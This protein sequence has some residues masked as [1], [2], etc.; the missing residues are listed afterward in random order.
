MK[1]HFYYSAYGLALIPLLLACTFTKQETGAG[2]LT[3]VSWNVHNLFDGVDNGYEYDEFKNSTG[4]NTEKYQGRLH[5]ISAALQGESG[6]KADIL[7]LIEVEN[8]TVV[9][10]LAHESNLDYE[11]SFFAGTADASVGLG[12]LSALPI[13]ETRTHSFH[14][15]DGSIPRPVAEVH[16]DTGSGPLVLLICHWKSKTGGEK[17]TESLRQACSTLIVRRLAEIEEEKE[18]TPVIIMGDLNE[19]YDEFSRIEAA[20]SCALLPGTD[21]AAAFVQK[22]NAG[23]RISTRPGFQNFL[24][25]TG[26]R[27]P[28]LKPGLSPFSVTWGIVYSPWFELEEKSAETQNSITGSYYYKDT[29]ETIDHFLLNAALFGENALSYGYFRVLSGPPF[30][31]A[32]GIPNSYNPRTGNGLSDHLPIVLVLNK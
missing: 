2:Y 9:Q 32:A 17:K 18:G 31:N 15:G 25:L 14:S 12:V 20:Y 7:A 11:W 13:T 6:I 23:A 26:E 8:E 29:W 10:D 21:E 16:V 19:N 4:W 1:K 5:S 24:V 27:P 3:I 28:K 22:K 30:T